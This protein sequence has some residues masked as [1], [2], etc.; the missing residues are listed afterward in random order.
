MTLASHM[1]PIVQTSTR[2]S[3]CDTVAAD[4]GAWSEFAIVGRQA[5][6]EQAFRLLVWMLQRAAA[7]SPAHSKETSAETYGGVGSEEMDIDL[8]P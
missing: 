6:L 8:I 2:S 3:I 5:A 4:E 7:I 1:I